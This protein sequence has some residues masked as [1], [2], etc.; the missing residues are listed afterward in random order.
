MGRSSAIPRKLWSE[1]TAAF[2]LRVRA[3]AITLL[4]PSLSEEECGILDSK[5]AGVLTTLL[6][7][8]SGLYFEAFLDRDQ[9]IDSGRT[10]QPLPV[11]PLTINIYGPAASLDS[12]SSILSEAKVFLQ[13]PTNLHP[14]SSYRNPHYLSWDEDVETP[15]FQPLSLLTAI[16]VAEIYE[17]LDQ[18]NLV[19]V[20]HELHQDSRIKTVLQR[21]DFGSRALNLVC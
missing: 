3:D 10:R 13:E 4:L 5:T 16:D 11:L 17:I 21:F 20:S 9:R 15:Q 1:T 12:V 19:Q 8:N 7:E 14:S 18:P 2:R 6:R